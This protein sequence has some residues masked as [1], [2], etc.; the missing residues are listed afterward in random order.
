MVPTIHLVRH[1]EG[2]HNLGIAN[3]LLPDPSLTP[4]GVNQCRRL[5]KDFPYMKQ[6]GLVVASPLRR[7]IY[8]ALYAF[9]DV[10]CE[11]E[12]QIIALPE[13]QETTDL[14]CDTGSSVDE[15]KQE[16]R[17]KPVDLNHLSRTW[18][19]KDGKWSP[20]PERV[21]ERAKEARKWLRSR[22]EDHV[23]VVT[24]GGF[25]HYLT[26]DWNG[27]SHLF[28]RYTP[29]TEEIQAPPTADGIFR[30]RLG[31]YRVSYLCVR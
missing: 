26:E 6:V 10:L 5:G 27:Y 19:R 8:T 24:H 16:F 31:Q 22:K 25:L 14:P 4:P 12:L 7:T 20:V 1:A 3:H 28:G 9:D 18:N 13:V 30:N 11:K 29:S 2:F 15:L 21:A 17:G 23:V